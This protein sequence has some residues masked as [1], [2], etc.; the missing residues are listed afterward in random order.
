MLKLTNIVKDYVT[1]D[2]TVSALKGVDLEFR[3]NEF[4]AILGHSGCGKTTLL[5]IIGGL[6][7]YTSGDLIINGKSTKDF[8]DS[9]W[10]T[11][12]NHSIGF[13][14]QSYN[15]IPHQS[16]LSNV[17]LALTLSGVSR[18]ERRRR[19]TEALEMVGLGD[20][21]HK[22]P[23]Q[24][25]G[26]QMQRVA[27]ARALVNDPD[28]LLADEPTGALDS[29]TS[30]QIMEILK[31]ISKNK[32][33]I[34]VTHNP[35]L[36]ETYATRIIRLKDGLIEGD[37]DPFDAEHRRGSITITKVQKSEAIEAD[38]KKNKKSG[39]E[40]KKKSMSFFTAF[41]LSLNNLLT[42]KGR[43]ILTSFAGSI[44]I[45]G[46]ALIFAVSQGTTAYID[47][48]QE[49]TLSSYPLT[50]EETTVDMTSLLSEFMGV[51]NDDGKDTG[52]RLD[53]AVYKDQIIGELVNALSKVEVNENDLSSF[54]AYLE[55]ELEKEDSPLREAISAIQYTYDLDLTIYTENADG[56]I[57]KSD[58]TELMAEM[59]ADYMIKSAGGEGGSSSGSSSGSASM[60]SSML[61]M[62]LWQEMLPGLDK[63]ETINQTIKNQ[64]DLVYGEWP[65]EYDEIVLVLDKDN[66]LDDLTLY[67]LGLLSKSD[68]DAIIDAAAS[69]QTLP[70][71]NKHW[72]FEE[73]CNEL[74]FKVILPADC[75][76][77]LGGGIYG[78]V[79]S[80]Q[81]FLEE[82]YK[83][84]LELKVSGIICLSDKVDSGMLS[85]GIGYTTMLTDYVIN[86]SANSEV[87]KAQ[88]ANPSVDVLTGLPFKAS[89]SS[90]SDAQ[91]A[92]EFK[93]YVSTL[94]TKEKA[95]L[96]VAIQ[97]LEA[98]NQQLDAVVEGV[99]AQMT[100]KDALIDQI[101]LYIAE[102]MGADAEQI[103]T[104][105]A[106][107][108][109]DKLKEML[110]PTIEEQA[111]LQIA[112]QVTAQLSAISDEQK[113]LTLDMSL[114]SYTTESCASYYDEFTVFSSS[115]Y[116]ENLVK[117]GNVDIDSPSS[118]NLYSTSFENK[119]K[120]KGIIDDYNDSMSELGQSDK[121]IAYT[122]YIGLMMS[123]ITQIINAI[124]YVLI[125]F[126]ATSLIVSSIMIGVITLISVQE[127]TKEIGI[128]RAIGASKKDVSRV[129]NAE[130]L[131]IG[132]SSGFVGI[133]ITLIL[134][135]V[136]NVILYA[137]TG[138]E[139]LK[140][141]LG[142]VPAIVLILISMALTL[143]AGLIP[144][145]VAAKKD[146]VIALRTE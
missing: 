46:I 45:I 60:L 58:T 114:S 111:K 79:S 41:L 128:L 51:K 131:I 52:D 20:Q 48:V 101:S 94:S 28:I 133:M 107:M 69:G 40:K 65:N 105:L 74:S 86:E 27:I 3:E 88:M 39:K 143:I 137:L 80:N 99:L 84:A 138:L 56:E 55:E 72:S 15:L 141:T 54:K 93:S 57:I 71:D 24:M 87:V 31:E 6:D 62:K 83:D 108:E 23:N 106:D 67:A 100:D 98:Q 140:A 142:V 112:E 30:V 122:D 34:M 115:S 123:S 134:I 73:I 139:M 1:G 102:E 33:I 145:R 49:T 18:E 63:G 14:F 75:Y 116:E 121:K 144:S 104:Y 119:D 76:K 61:S 2:T 21:I 77:N 19:A 126:V 44:G 53:D 78:D 103:K 109:L 81:S 85:S 25:S 43:T 29:E 70:D 8:K 11:Y 36:A 130:T 42:K 50:L 35:E 4:V 26:G 16:V 117:F 118:I 5:N 129:F 59:I 89:S 113:A 64:Y 120:I 17:E 9:D 136:I 68:I 13:V 38:G 37:T 110:R 66:E 47:H 22:K 95:E 92:E 90:M 32:L 124:T 146:P 10:D 127:R 132:F 12:R 97:C 125:A 7:K 82:L 96:F 91:K 135:A